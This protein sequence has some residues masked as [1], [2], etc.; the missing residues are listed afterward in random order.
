MF[1]AIGLRR[2]AVKAAVAAASIALPWLIKNWIWL[3]NPVSPFFNRLFPNPYVHVS[4]EDFYRG[5]FSHYGLSTLKPLFWIVTVTGQLGG[6]IGPLFLLAPLSLL[7]LRSKAG[8]HCLIAACFFLL[9]YPGNIGARFLIPVLPF[10]AF[11]IA[12]AL[13]FSQVIVTV[14]MAAAAI[15]AWPRVIDRYRSPTGGWQ[16]TTVPWQAALHLIPP[17]PGLRSATRATSAQTINST[18]PQNKILWSTIPLAEAY[19]DRD[20]RVYYYSA[21]NEEVQDILLTPVHQEMQPTWNLRFTFPN[22]P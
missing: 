19:I 4:F 5:Y 13:D 17:A 1:Y 12:M 9:P 15:L 7:A 21:E 18:V 20:V 3:G 6:Q 10:I 2:K 16:I 8:R 14:L 22:A 11:G